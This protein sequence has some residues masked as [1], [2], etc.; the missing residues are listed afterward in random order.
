MAKFRKKP[1]VI[2]ARQLPDVMDVDAR[3]EFDDWI[4]EAEGHERCRY[5]G[6]NLQIHTLEGIMYADPGDWI[7]IGVQGEIYPCKPGIFA[8]TYEPA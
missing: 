8:A 6:E 3:I 7:I 1:M 2:E 4:C 5:Q